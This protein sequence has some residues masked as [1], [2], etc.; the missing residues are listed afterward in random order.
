MRVLHS[1]KEKRILI[2]A[3]LSPSKNVYLRIQ[4]MASHLV[5]GGDIFKP[6]RIGFSEIL[7][8]YVLALLHGREKLGFDGDNH[9]L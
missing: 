1:F 5:L 6:E 7:K 2:K 8:R 4:L 9:I 3:S